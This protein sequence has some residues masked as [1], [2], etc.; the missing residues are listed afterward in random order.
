MSLNI[1]APPDL[2]ILRDWFNCYPPNCD[3]NTSMVL[4]TGV[5]PIYITQTCDMGVWTAWMLF[6]SFF[7]ILNLGILY[8][9]FRKPEALRSL[10]SHL[11][12]WVQHRKP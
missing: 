10:C 7:L 2:S 5:R 6:N 4:G 3:V 9:A 8:Y 1:T 11:S 12:E